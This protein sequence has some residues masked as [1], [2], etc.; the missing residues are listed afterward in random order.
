MSTTEQNKETVRR[1]VSA[2]GRGDWAGLL[3]EATDDF[4]LTV[5]MTPAEANT[6]RGKEKVAKVLRRA[7]GDRLE[8]GV[9]VMTIENLL[10]DGEYVVEQ[11]R[12]RART[13]D[14]KDYNNAYCRVWRVVHGK[15][16]A[17]HEYLD[18]ELARACL[19]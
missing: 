19:F 6:I 8:G 12:G 1:A 3:A 5:M 14:G 2:M 4:T 7:L 15:I 13:K 17:L 9:I 18:T 16:A 10:A 11:S